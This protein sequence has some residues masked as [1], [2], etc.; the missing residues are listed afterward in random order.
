LRI[1]VEASQY[2]C[3]RTMSIMVRGGDRRFQNRRARQGDT[4]PPIRR[5][6]GAEP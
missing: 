4:D 1:M 5:D 2:M 3:P 6:V